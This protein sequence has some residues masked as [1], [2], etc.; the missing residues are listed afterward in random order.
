MVA[1]V[2]LQLL[3]VI[4][5][6]ERILGDLHHA[7][8]VLVCMVLLRLLGKK[9]TTAGRLLDDLHQFERLVL[10]IHSP[11]MLYRPLQMLESVEQERAGVEQLLLLQLEELMQVLRLRVLRCVLTGR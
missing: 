5:L 7:S 2:V 8:A 1:I 6:L 11:P 4:L 3:L 9:G 10:R